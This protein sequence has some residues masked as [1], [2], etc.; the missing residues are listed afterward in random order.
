MLP[1]LRV[2]ERHELVTRRGVATWRSSASSVGDAAR[3]LPA[4][5]YEV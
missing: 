2:Y 5:S 3:G 4:W 1:Q